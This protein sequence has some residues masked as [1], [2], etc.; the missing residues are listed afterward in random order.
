MAVA[1]ATAAADQVDVFLLVSAFKFVLL[2]LVVVSSWL[3]VWCA[4]FAAVL[5]YTK[6]FC[7]YSR[8]SSSKGRFIGAQQ[9]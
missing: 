7:V 4:F 5:Q 9:L 1:A 6:R 8:S 2:R 3:V